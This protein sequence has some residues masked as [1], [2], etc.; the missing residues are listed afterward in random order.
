MA[1]AELE[2]IAI[3]R[4]VKALD[5]FELDTPVNKGVLASIDALLNLK[6]GQ[7]RHLENIITTIKAK[8]STCT[9]SFKLVVHSTCRCTGLVSINI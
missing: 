4:K 8:V 3:L 6:E 9:C 7:R 5:E 1:V 2:S